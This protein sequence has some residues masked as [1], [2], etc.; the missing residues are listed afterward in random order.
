MH[1]TIFGNV[2]ALV[3]RMYGARKSVY[4]T[5]WRDL[6]DFSILHSV[7]KGLKQRMQDYFQTMWQLNHGIDPVEVRKISSIYTGI[8]GLLNPDGFEVCLL[9]KSKLFII[10]F[11][12][13]QWRQSLC[14][15]RFSVV[16]E[17]SQNSFSY[18]SDP[19]RLP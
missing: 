14:L 7:P 12:L 4:Q 2:T 11:S 5:K 13:V 19:E 6:K 15:L 17:L 18:Y 8:L 1:A 3:Q 9:T 10:F 16:F